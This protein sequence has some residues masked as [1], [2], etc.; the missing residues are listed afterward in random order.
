MDLRIDERGPPWILEVNPNPDIAPDA[1][2]ARMARVAGIDY[3]ALIRRVCEAG[4]K[5]KIETRSPELWQRSLHLSGMSS[6]ARGGPVMS[7]DT[8]A[9]ATAVAGLVAAFRRRSAR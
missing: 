1:G 7:A 3:G 6:V 8:V 4:L 9:E 2:L 5:Q